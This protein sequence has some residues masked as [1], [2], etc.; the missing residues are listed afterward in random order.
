MKRVNLVKDKKLDEKYMEYYE[1]MFS[2]KKDVKPKKEE[3]LKVTVYI[4]DSMLPVL[5]EPKTIVI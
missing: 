1:N 3:D 5:V 4:Q 2:M